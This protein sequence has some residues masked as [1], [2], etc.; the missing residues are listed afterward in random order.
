MRRLL[1]LAL[2]SVV[3]G[4]GAVPTLSAQQR[5]EVPWS[6][7]EASWIGPRIPYDSSVRL[8]APAG[9]DFGTVDAVSS[10]L[11]T[12]VAT[13]ESRPGFRWTFVAATAGSLVGL[14]VGGMGTGLAL[15]RAGAGSVTLLAMPVGA[16][17]GS[18]LLSGRSGYFLGAPSPSATK[19]TAFAGGL[20]GLVTG[21]LGA[22]VVN[23]MSHEPAPVVAAFV[24]GQGAM[25]AYM[26]TQE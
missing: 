25:A 24:L 14:Y 23:Q 18:T 15:D 7:A 19:G 3:G 10:A 13:E 9:I 2:S 21:G 20:L 17:V 5:P 22:A 8:H 12:I 16:A 4:L 26:L 1:T 6:L 11:D